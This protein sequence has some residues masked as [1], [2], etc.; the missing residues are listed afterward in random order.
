[1]AISE[2]FVDPS[3]N[4]NTGTGTLLDPYGDLRFCI[5]Q[6]T[7]DLVNGTRI[8][9]KTGMWEVL[10]E[11][12]H[13]TFADVTSSIAWFPASGGPFVLEGYTAQA[14]DG[15]I[16]GIDGDTLWST[17]GNGAYSFV[18]FRNLQIK[19]TGG[20]FY[21]IRPG[22]RSS[23]LNCEFWGGTASRAVYSTGTEILIQHCNIHDVT[24]TG[25]DVLHG[26]V[27]NNR[28]QT[29]SNAAG[30]NQ[31]GPNALNIERNLVIC[32]GSGDGIRPYY[33]GIMRSNSIYSD[34]GTGRGIVPTAGTH[35]GVILSNLIEG[36]SGVGGYGI[37]LDN[38]VLVKSVGGNAVY[39]CTTPYSLSPSKHLVEDLGDNEILTASPF[40]DA[41]NGD[42]SPVATGNVR[43]GHMP[44]GW[45]V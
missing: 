3:L 23:I 10:T 26:D 34:G 19:D 45:L 12:L 5:E 40:V 22:V 13:T 39:D 9:L 17:L 33:G 6:E 15:G 29:N 36:F 35:G 27:F 8:N 38:T 1:M 30:I 21:M 16:G 42:F 18:H 7:F 20:T 44:S 25:I 11:D 31:N 4:S 37:N 14:G 32:T 28:I 43:E 2:L 24:G 41:A